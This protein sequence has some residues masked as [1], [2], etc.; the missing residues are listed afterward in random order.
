MVKLSKELIG[1]SMI[2]LLLSIISKKESY[3]YEI[4]QRVK[5]L[6]ND[7][8]AFGEG[9]LYPVLHKLEKKNLIEAHWK[10]ADTGRKRKYY[11]ITETGLS[12]LAEEK[13]NWTFMNQ[14]ILKLWKTQPNLI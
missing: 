8:I 2:P 9:T 4:I 13:E 14:I 12:Q 10:T 7:E 5:E 3:G 11:R 1:A 6:S